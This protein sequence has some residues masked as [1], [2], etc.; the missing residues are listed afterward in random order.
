MINESRYFATNEVET[1]QLIPMS[2]EDLATTPFEFYVQLAAQ[3][4]GLT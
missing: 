2:H 4:S 3:R 1:L